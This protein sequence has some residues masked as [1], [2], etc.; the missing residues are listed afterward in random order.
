MALGEFGIIQ[1][2]FSALGSADDVVLGVGDDCALLQ[3]QPGEE[4]AVS[5]D[6]AVE[7]VHFPEDGFPED[8]AYRC[9]AA[10]ASDLAAMGARPLGMTLSLTLPSVDELWLQAFSEGLAAV[11]KATGLPLVGG[12]TTRGPLTIGV[13]VL[14]AVPA[15][16]ALRR[17]GAAVG[18]QLC[19]SGNPGDAAGGLALLQGE[20]LPEPEFGEHLYQRFYR[21][22]SRLKLGQSLLGVATSCID[23]S[24]GMLADAG[25]LADASGVR[26]RIDPERLPLSAALQSHPAPQQALQ[27]ALGGGDDYE[28]LFTLPAGADCPP[29]CTVIGE[30]LDGSGVECPI[31]FDTRSGFEH[32]AE[33]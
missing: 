24:D 3:L 15:G 29:G 20:W 5:T 26:L 2:Y 22:S 10:A 25:H 1:R 7:G 21:P 17:E 27:W 9:V 30:V 14:G 32:F 33:G 4:L 8:I 28:L 16:L 18:D 13:Q 6:T 31:E 23:I 19:M 11:V 12:D